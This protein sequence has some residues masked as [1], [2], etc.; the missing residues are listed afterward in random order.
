[1]Y[2]STVQSAITIE[3]RY[4]RALYG[5]DCEPVCLPASR[6]RTVPSEAYNAFHGVRAVKWS[7][8]P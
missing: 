4:N 7:A 2:S 6:V 5:W 3:R 1:M 8:K